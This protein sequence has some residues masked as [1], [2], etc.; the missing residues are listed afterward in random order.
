MGISVI[1]HPKNP[2]VPSSH[3]NVRLFSILD[4]NNEIK[5]W[6]IGGGYDLTPFLPTKMMLLIGTNLPKKI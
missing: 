1:S 2:H 3:M 4:N 6:W 5:D